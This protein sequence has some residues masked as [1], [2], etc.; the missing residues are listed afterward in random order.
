VPVAIVGGAWLLFHE[1]A[2]TAIIGVAALTGLA[3]V[4]FLAKMIAN[5]AKFAEQA[6]TDLAG[7]EAQD[8]EAESNRRHAIVGRLAD[9]YCLEMGD[10]A[11][12][13]IRAGLALPS[14][15]WLNEHLAELGEVWSI[16]NIQ[17]LS[18][19]T[20][21]ILAGEWRYRGHR[22][23]SPAAIKWAAFFDSLDLPWELGNESWDRANGVA[24]DFFLPQLDAWYVAE[25]AFDDAKLE[26]HRETAR[27]TGRRVII[28]DGQP[29]YAISSRLTVPWMMVAGLGVKIVETRA[30]IGS[31]S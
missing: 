22:M 21:E 15:D 23:R 10:Q 31:P 13:A 12:P 4:V 3:L 17:G 16:F 29:A 8:D 26:R 6:R 7:Q 27:Q 18:Y 20:F 9:L 25:Y 5:V 14:E 19:Q 2:L 11:A 1:L 28:A 30:C 24:P